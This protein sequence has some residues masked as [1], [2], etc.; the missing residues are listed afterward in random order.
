MNMREKM[1]LF[2][3]TFLL[4]TLLFLSICTPPKVFS[5]ESTP[6]ARRDSTIVFGTVEPTTNPDLQPNSFKRAFGLNI[7]ISTNGFGLGL[8]YRREFSDELSGALD[9]TVSESRD[10]D[11]KEFTDIYGRPITIGKVNRFLILPVV[12]SIE[13]RMF[14]DEILD[15]FRPY[16]TGGIGPTMIYVFPYNEEYFSALGKGKLR[17]TFGGYIGAGA[18][19]GTEPSSL[20]GLNFRYYY[21]PYF[22]GIESLQGVSKTQFGG[23]YISLSFGS[24]W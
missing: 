17:Y 8:F 24:A 22:S 23:V 16:V 3:K 2:P 21:V 9:F 4:P 19:F 13:K 12:F 6:A 5:Q 7:M 1:K 18:Y 15:N 20:L 14:K 10:D 11:E